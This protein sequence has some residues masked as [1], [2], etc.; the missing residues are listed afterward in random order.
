MQMNTKN[1]TLSM[2]GTTMDY[3]RFG[4]GPGP[5]SCCRDWEKVC[6]A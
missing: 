2:D 1:G 4:S 3:I 5:W 6:A